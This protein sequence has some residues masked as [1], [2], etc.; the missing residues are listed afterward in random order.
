[1]HT[2]NIRVGTLVCDVD[3]VLVKG[4]FAQLAE[5]L[6]ISIIPI[7]TESQWQ[8]LAEPWQRWL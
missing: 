4:N 8:D 2:R 6:G 7:N 5:S 3:N 1:M